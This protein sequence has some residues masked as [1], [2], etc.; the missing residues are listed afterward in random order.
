[1]LT[2]RNQVFDNH[3]PLTFNYFTL[4]EVFAAMIFRAAAHVR[5]WQSQILS[6]QHALRDAGSGYAGDHF[7][8]TK[9]LLD[10]LRQFLTDIRTDGGMGQRHPVVTVNRRLPTR[11]P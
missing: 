3:D 11:S 9:L 2:G 4:N 6:Y 7:H 10:K 8:R 1:A 5:K